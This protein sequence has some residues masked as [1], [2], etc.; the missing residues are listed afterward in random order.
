MSRDSPNFPKTQQE[1]FGKFDGFFLT[2]RPESGMIFLNRYSESLCPLL[3]GQ[4][5]VIYIDNVFLDGTRIAPLGQICE[6]SPRHAAPILSWSVLGD[7]D[8]TKQDSYS[9]AVKI[10]GETVYYDCV[11]TERQSVV[12]DFF[13]FPA[14]STAELILMV[15]SSTRYSDTQTV[16]LFNGCLDTFPGEW[17]TSREDQGERVLRFVKDFTVSKPVKN[18]VMYFCGLGYHQASVNRK[19]VC[20]ASLD[21]AHANY[22]KTCYYRVDDSVSLKQGKNRIE[23]R[24]APGWR[25]NGTDFMWSMLGE[26]KIEFYGDSILW[27]YL[28]V[29]YEDGTA[30]DIVTD[31]SWECALDPRTSSIFNGETFDAA[32][33]MEFDECDKLPVKAVPAPGGEMRPMILQPIRRK[34]SFPP[35]EI[36]NPKPGVFVVDFGQNIAG[37]VTLHLHEG[38][39]SGDT[40][41]MTH[42]EELNEDGTVYTDTLRGAA[43]TDTYI[44]AGDERDTFFWRPT[45]TYHGFRYC[46]ITGLDHL[47]RSDIEAELIHTDLENRSSFTCGSPMV[48]AIQEALV[49]TERDNM[50]S[51]LTDCPQRDERMAWMN[52]ATVRFEETPYNFDASR[53]FP[54]ILQDIKNE[55]RAEGQFTCC[56]PFIY[57]GLPA[58]PV[59]SSYLV[60][61]KEALMH[62]GEL[63]AVDEFFDGMAAWEDYLLSRSPDGTVDYSYYGDWAA[64][65]YACLSDEGAPSAV[66]PGVVMS[67][68]YSYYNCKLLADFA[69]RTGRTEAEAKYTEKAEYVRKA[70]LDKWFDPE[71]GKVATGSM[72]CQAFALWLGILPAEC[73]AKA[74]EVMRNDLVEKN[75]KFTTGNLNT[76]YLMDM[77][78]KHGYIEDAWKVITSDEYPSFGF[79]FQ[80]EATTIWERF[81]MK[82][83]PGMNSHNHPMYGA[84]GYWFYAYLGGIIPTEPGFSRVSIK[85]YFP[86]K[87]TSCH[88]VVD[89]VMGDISVRWSKRYGKL[90]LFVQTPFGVTADVDFD[91]KVTTVGA[92]YHVFE[93]ELEA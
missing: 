52:D 13:D 35:K 32:L 20:H 58:D 9:L 7:E 50:H 8:N 47:K 70:F 23:I 60:A 18:A 83:N 54:K 4:I 69:R 12:L 16:T 71:T 39:T 11:E 44:A 33:N 19:T 76:R 26:R 88:A 67:T 61:A 79:M 53:I 42:T 5:T 51:I 56:A 45:F 41:T 49:M 40:V 80:N 78:T 15:K 66:T 65:A 92:G 24:V 10:D 29:D 36:T 85:P 82:K 89:T 73:E 91:G 14:G 57:G 48:N 2:F 38:M 28:R 90:Y 59:C 3:K 86:E 55:Q 74:A 43:Q 46:Q 22:A 21:P 25:K 93:K 81:E 84:V 34:R 64:P 1:N 27:A 68:G 75:Y 72:G 30:E 62:Y 31:T 6:F 17:I 77:L 63:G 37:T 87:L